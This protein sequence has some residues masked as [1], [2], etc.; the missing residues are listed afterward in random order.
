MALI[1]ASANGHLPVVEFLLTQPGVNPAAQD[2]GAIIYAS[3]FG[4]LSVV[5]FLV[6]QTGVNPSAQNNWALN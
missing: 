3:R 4:H 1:W 2:N 6:T 5:E